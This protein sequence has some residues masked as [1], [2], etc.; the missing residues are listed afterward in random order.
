MIF[1]DLN[2]WVDSKHYYLSS[3]LY[4]KKEK[5]RGIDDIKEK[6]GENDIAKAVVTSKMAVD[7]DWDV[8][9]KKLLKTCLGE[10]IEGLHY[11]FI[12][13]PDAY[14]TYDFSKYVKEAYK[15]KVRLFRVFPK[16][17]LFYVNDYYMKK[18]YK[19]LA[20]YRFPV[21]IDLKQ[22]DITGNKYFDIDAL[23]KVLEENT[24]LP[25]ILETSLK[26]CMF[27]RFYF[28]LLERYK[29]L[30]I[31]VSGMLL[32]D[33]IEGYV[34]KFGSERLIFGTNHPNIPMGI[35]TNRIIFAQIS[36]SDK[37][38]IAFDNLDKIMK[39]IEI[40]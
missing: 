21:M 32:Y 36:E 14:Y 7:Y 1:F 23:Q 10:E 19:V 2:N 24:D 13:T 8:G 18:I 29:N 39:E 3:D 15:R 40:A 30:Y 4:E 17:Q 6:L 20:G 37:Q 27:S 28:P 35:N 34:E 38:N 33:Q 31:E 5:V 12:L 11:G 25:F 16:R 22:L 26:Q 9:N